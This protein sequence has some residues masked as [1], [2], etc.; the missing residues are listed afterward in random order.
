MPAGTAPVSFATPGTVPARS[1]NTPSDAARPTC[2]AGTV[3]SAALSG[4][5]SDAGTPA[6]YAGNVRS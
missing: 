3:P 1:A 4:T 6:R 5:P 2:S